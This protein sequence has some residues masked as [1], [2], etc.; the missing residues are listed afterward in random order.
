MPDHPEPD[1]YTE[2]A[3]QVDADTRAKV[4]AAATAQAQQDAW[5]ERRVVMLAFIDQIERGLE[6]AD[7]QKRHS[8]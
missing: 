1:D 4:L 6:E 5:D 2:W 3:D 8:P 7:T